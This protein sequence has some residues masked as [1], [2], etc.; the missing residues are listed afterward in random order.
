MS[1]PYGML[2][3][4][5]KKEKIVEKAVVITTDGSKEVVEFEVGGS[6]DLLQQKVGGWFQVVALE[7]READ[8]WLNEEG[9]LNNL[10][11]NPIATSL[12]RSEYGDYD[13]IVGDVV[14][15]G[16]VDDNGDT[17]GLTDEQVQEFLAY[18]PRFT[19]I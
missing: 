8:L 14:I 10:P 19:V 17:L 13:F 11:R 16:G 9:K 5:H 1:L 4:P 3:T 18:Q 6:Y 12:F 2:K 15:T 7:Q